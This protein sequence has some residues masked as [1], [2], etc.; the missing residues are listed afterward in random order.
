M[1]KIGID[2]D[3]TIINYSNSF[4]KVLLKDNIYFDKRI[5]K[6]EKIKKFF[7]RQKK[8]KFFT[9]LQGRV[10][11]SEI[12]QAEIF[13]GF[14]DFVKC[15]KIKSN[16]IYLEIVSHKTKFPIE[17]KKINL[18]YKSLLFLKK[19]K[20]KLK[21]IFHE[22]FD[23]KIKYINSNNF[24]YFI[25]DLEK[26]VEKIDNKKTIP[27]LFKKKN[28]KIINFDDWFQI[29]KFFLAKIK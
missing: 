17:G 8:F 22:K 25:D 3:N 10:Y 29:K 24:D 23:H 26:V 19:K 11:G 2:L 27:I 7:H 13:D 9:E 6:K 15:C 28:K 16:Y 12:N 1:I 21:I 5:K 18:R 14:K 20:I 4:R